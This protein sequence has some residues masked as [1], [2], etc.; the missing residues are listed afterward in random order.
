MRRFRRRFCRLLAAARLIAGASVALVAAALL[1]S[2][3]SA[4]EPVYPPASRIGLVPP[5]DFVVSRNFVGFQHN[6][7][8][9]SILLADLPSYAFEP[10]EKEAAAAVQQS[11]FPVERRDITLPGGGRGFVLSGRQESPQG[12]VLKWTLV[13]QSDQTTAVVTVLVP[14]AVKDAAPDDTVRAALSTV[15]VRRNIPAE[16]QLS[17]LPFTLNDLAG[18]RIV[19]VQPGAA[20]MLTDGPSDSVEASEQ[21]LFVLSIV[22]GPPP[23]AS[24]RDTVARR[25]F[26]EVPGLRD[27]RIV[28][29]EPL[30]L[31]NSQ[32]YEILVEGK[33]IKTGVDVNAVQ[34]LRFGSGAT[35]RAVGIARKEGWDATFTRFRK[36]R[37][38]LEPR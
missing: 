21:P 24:D 12:P 20:A 37:D 11:P 7:K 2:A 27:A 19:R 9:A 35:L 32:G 17:V 4:A 10:L 8:Q 28:R 36:L 30:R 14:E 1:A 29:A 6:D 15:T 34:W 3:A 38:G 31:M 22:P 18:F 26:G 23:Q 16:E 25:L 5:P 13:G 33:D